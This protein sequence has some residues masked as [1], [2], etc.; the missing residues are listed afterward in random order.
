M[1]GF[2]QIWPQPKGESRAKQKVRERREYR[3]AR[4]RCREA[5]YERDGWRCRICLRAVSIDV[6][7]WAP[8][9]A[10][11]HED[12]PRSL[13]G[14]PTNPEDCVLLCRNCHMPNGR[15]INKRMAAKIE[16][17]VGEKA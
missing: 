14:D 15:H 17:I 1:I 3:R 2:N 9:F 12:P 10:H 7:T 8:N 6:S 4:K 13:G 5:V 16:R 11:V